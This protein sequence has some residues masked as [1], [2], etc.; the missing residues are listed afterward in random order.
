MM[1]SESIEYLYRGVHLAYLNFFNS[2]YLAVATCK[3]K[4][5]ADSHTSRDDE[6]R[7]HIPS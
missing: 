1:L 2:T 7:A 4:K 6:T 3:K 5:S